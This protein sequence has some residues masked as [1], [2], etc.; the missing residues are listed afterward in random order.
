MYAIFGGVDFG[1]GS[2]TRGRWGEAWG[3]SREV[4]DDSVAPVWEPIYVWLIF[5]FV[6]LWSA[7]GGRRGDHA[8]RC[9]VRLTLAAFGIVLR[10]RELRVRKAVF[11][12]V[13]DAASEPPSRSPRSW[14]RTAS[15]PWSASIA[16]GRVPLGGAAGDPWSSWVNPTSVLVGAV[17]VSAQRL[18]R[19]VLPGLRRA[20]ALRTHDG[21]LLPRRAL[22]AGVATGVAALAGILVLSNDAEY[23]Y[24]GLTARALPLV[25]LSA[26]AGV[27]A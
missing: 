6:L 24:D 23:L 22:G 17:A 25:I 13:T 12:L 4:I 18:P 10:G 19:R 14:C 21:G 2:G 27:G 16:S 1:A 3:A 9:F 8:S 7:P 5:V 15:A 26:L 20:P 11:A